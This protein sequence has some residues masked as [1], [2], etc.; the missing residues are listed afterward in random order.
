MGWSSPA[1]E[2][3]EGDTKGEGWKRD[4]K[5]EDSFSQQIST[6][7]F[8]LLEVLFGCLRMRE[9]GW[10]WGWDWDWDWDRG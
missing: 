4:V 3:W 8:R 10:E 6:S 2:G 9:E 1:G 5:G 7:E